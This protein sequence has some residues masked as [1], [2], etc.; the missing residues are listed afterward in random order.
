MRF[1]V[2]AT[3]GSLLNWF[4]APLMA[5]DKPFK[6][7]VSKIG[8]APSHP[9]LGLRE[10]AR[11]IPL[12][13][14]PD[15][16]TLAKASRELRKSL[17]FVGNENIASGTAFVISQEH[18]LIATN[19]H[20][21]DIFHL[22]KN[23]MRAYLNQSTITY[24]VEEVYYHPGVYRKL[25]NVLP[26][27]SMDP[28]E[29]EVMY[30]SPDVA[31]LK[32][33]NGPDLPDAVTLATWDE[34]SDLF[35]SDVGM[36]GFP[37]YNNKTW[38]GPGQNP[39][40]TVHY[41]TID[42]VT[43]F[44]QNAGDDPR[45]LQFLQHTASSWP[46]FSGSPLYL[47][48]GHVVGLHN[49][50]P[51]ASARGI[52]VG[53]PHGIRIDALWELLVYHKLNVAI[54]VDKKEVLVERYFQADPTSEKYRKAVALVTE[55]KKETFGSSIT[56]EKIDEAI[57]LAPQYPAAYA[58]RWK[59]NRMMHDFAA[60]LAR[61]EP[62]PRGAIPLP[63]EAAGTFDPDAA[64]KIELAD[65]QKLLDLAPSDLISW[66]FAVDSNWK[67]LYYKDLKTPANLV[68]RN[69]Y[70]ELLKT[71]EQ[72]LTNENVTLDLRASILLRRS[73]MLRTKPFNDYE[74]AVSD[75]EILA[76]AEPSNP[77]YLGEMMAV[78][79]EGEDQKK[80]V[81]VYDK[82]VLLDK[83]KSREPR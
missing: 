33:A 76:A 58:V 47:A 72:L 65:A 74:R 4:S 37:G 27:R 17:M 49:S 54:P 23:K 5:Q 15:S 77:F 66:V 30:L 19:A 1:L 55:L 59:N 40:A 68:D 56:K 78:F 83:A 6:I 82:L 28:N 16:D 24:E 39:A 71:L 18:R 70:E 69:R 31:V 12:S 60:M 64:Y 41:G 57:A 38:P 48:N 79:N 26:V 36:L 73:R 52:T 22:G 34:V 51:Q 35:G 21:G 53:I 14:K 44:N 46:G 43:D 9:H 11:S 2:L 10:P 50:A 3:V 20:V 32:L 75:L 81:A 67:Y 25:E 13:R 7:D 29:G 62:L 42:R 8:V 63:G 61:V 80:F 45:L